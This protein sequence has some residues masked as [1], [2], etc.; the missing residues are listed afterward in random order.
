MNLNTF[1]H[2]LVEAQK[3]AA[4]PFAHVEWADDP[5]T[6]GRRAYSIG[7]TSPEAVQT[8]ID[9]HMRVVEMTGGVG[10]FLNPLSYGAA[11]RKYP[12]A[13]FIDAPF[14]SLGYTIIQSRAA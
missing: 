1:M 7:G 5:R 10:E 4:K 8:E 14:V 11:A 12:Q 2:S 9:K 13:T 6:P 3:A